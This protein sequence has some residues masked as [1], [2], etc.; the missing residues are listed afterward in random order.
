MQ[1]R[2]LSKQH[3]PQQM[4]AYQEMAHAHMPTSISARRYPRDFAGGTSST[5]QQQKLT[6]PIKSLQAKHR[7]LEMQLAKLSAEVANQ[8]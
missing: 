1:G 8:H 4:A 3:K 5:T 2:S 7:N 6:A